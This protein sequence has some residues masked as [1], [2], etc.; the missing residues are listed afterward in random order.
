MHHY[1]LIYIYNYYD[2]TINFLF[3]DIQYDIS[4]I[5]MNDCRARRW[6]CELG[7]NLS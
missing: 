1:P 4:T 2:I 5:Q 3:L 7:A 6:E